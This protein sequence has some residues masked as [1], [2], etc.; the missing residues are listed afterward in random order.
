MYKHN[1]A[2]AEVVKAKVLEMWSD[3]YKA[4]EVEFVKAVKILRE[5]MGV[6]EFIIKLD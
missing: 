6:E 5:S 2:L 1:D 4:A 3:A